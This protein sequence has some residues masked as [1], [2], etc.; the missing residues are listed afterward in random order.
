MCV[1]TR[2]VFKPQLDAEYGC[3]SVMLGLSNG[4]GESKAPNVKLG[5]IKSKLH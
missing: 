2:Q 4:D 1:T 5:E 3:V